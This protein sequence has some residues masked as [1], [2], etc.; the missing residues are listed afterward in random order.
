MLIYNGKLLIGFSPIC[1]TRSILA[2]GEAN[3]FV[4]LGDND[5]AKIDKC[6]SVFVVRNTDSR[7][8]D[9][10]YAYIEKYAELQH[11]TLQDQWNRREDLLSE[12][13]S[14]P[15]EL[16]DWFSIEPVSFVKQQT[17]LDKYKT[18]DWDFIR[19]ENFDALAQKYELS[20]LKGMT[21]RSMTFVDKIKLYFNNY[22]TEKQ[23]L[24][25]EDYELYNSAG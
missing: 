24:Y 6:V 12:I 18:I 14:D 25:S 8:A 20:N 5:L 22:Q 21:A 9:Q 17:I 1:A 2:W 23:M 19:L 4:E 11:T 10:V 7:M 15:N 3:G 16:K 13:L